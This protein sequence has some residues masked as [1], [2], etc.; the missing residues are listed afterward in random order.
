MSSIFSKIVSGEI[1]SYKIAEEKNFF[2][3]LDINPL[4]KGHALVVS[5]KEIDYV[6]DI[7]DDLYKG[8]L[9]FTK[10]VA[11]AIEKSVNCIRMGMVVYGLDIPHAHIHLI[12]LLGS[13]D[14]DFKKPPL[15]LTPEEFKEIAERINDEFEKLK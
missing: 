9:M 5:K 4:A 1:P 11:L 10:K 3:F 6:F 14:I 15:K 7:E 12:P 2:A 13:N 8:L